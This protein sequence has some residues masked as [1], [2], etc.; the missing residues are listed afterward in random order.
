[1]LA[2][3]IV[4]TLIYSPQDESSDAQF[5]P[6]NKSPSPEPSEARPPPPKSILKSPLNRADTNGYATDTVSIAGRVYVLIIYVLITSGFVRA[7]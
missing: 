4:L 7:S 2:P 3:N 5:S 6:G 1:M